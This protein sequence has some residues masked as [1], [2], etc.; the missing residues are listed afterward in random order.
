M[1]MTTAIY[2]KECKN[3]LGVRIEKI[4]PPY[5]NKV[6]PTGNCP[7]LPVLL[8]SDD[9]VY[10]GTTPRS[11]YEAQFWFPMPLFDDPVITDD[12]C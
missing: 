7:R 4:I 10:V 6:N 11:Y 9:L 3:H 12:A 5:W 8:W 1:T 2:C